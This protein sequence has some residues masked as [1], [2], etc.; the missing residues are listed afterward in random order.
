MGLLPE[1][2]EVIT[3]NG[4]RHVYFKLPDFDEAPSIKNTAGKLGQGLD[5]R[6]DGGYVVA[7]P[8]IH[9]S[10]KAYYWSVD[11]GSEFAAAPVWLIGLVSAPPAV[12]QLDDFRP[13]QHWTALARHGVSKGSRN[14]TIASLAGRY[15]ARGIHP[16]EV[17]ELLLAWNIARNSTAVAG[18]RGH[19]HRQVNCNEGIS[20]SGGAT[21][22]LMII[23]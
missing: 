13:Q 23:S 15:L 7:P 20:P 5:T 14:T 17:N 18:C 11:L 12:T 16:A 19:E 22:W 21:K 1:T 4:G 6:G 8:S 3:G 10:G 2:V 9:P